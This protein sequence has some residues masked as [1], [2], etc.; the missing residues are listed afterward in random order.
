MLDLTK[1][2]GEKSPKNKKVSTTQLAKIRKA[3]ADHPIKAVIFCIVA[4]TLLG[5]S[6]FIYL[7]PSQHHAEKTAKTS[8]DTTPT[9]Q[10][11]AKL[12]YSPLTGREVANESAIKSPVTAIMIE[13]SPDARPQSGLKKA[14]I[15]YEAVTEGGITRFLA[16]YQNE[17]PSIVGPVRSLRPY[18]LDWATP[19]N[20]SIA[21]VGGSPDALR[22][23]RDGS[24]R[25][26]D[27]F[28]NSKSYWR[29]LDRYAPH[30]MYTNFKLLDALNK[31]KGY[32]SS[33]FIGFNRQDGK[34]AKKPNATDISITM[35][36]PLYNTTYKYN[37]N[38][39][40]YTRYLAGA[41]H[42]DREAGTITPDAVVGMIVSMRPD[43][44]GYR[45]IIDT[46]ST[47]V[48]YIFQ[49]G[50]ATKAVW[51]KKTPRAPLELLNQD[52]TPFSL[53]RGQVWV[54]AVPK[55]N[56]VSWD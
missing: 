8:T 37:K 42:K 54:S 33:T 11:T 19:Y 24:H 26:I 23:V 12:F 35:S 56:G 29:A 48:A 31:Q 14:G 10:K 9:A 43:A 22:R 46:S 27:Q 7:F 47:G 53:V 50:N 28:F 32:T 6:L 21:H 20:A 36:G 4:M 51:R 40:N 49:N 2:Y 52:G 18:Y 30:N 41:K 45:Q 39:N 5:I 34:P 16:I 17:K 1:R 44:S 15:V 3:I 38:D 25:D 13:N 55:S